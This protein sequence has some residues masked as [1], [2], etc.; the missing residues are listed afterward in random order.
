[1]GSTLGTDAPRA[2][3]PTDIR[4]LAPAVG[5]WLCT[6]VLLGSQSTTALT[7]GA[8][9]L[10][11]ALVL[12]PALRL[13]SSDLWVTPVL[14][15]L[16]CAAAGALA[17]GA[18][19]AGVEASPVAELAERESGV[20]SEVVVSLDPRPRDGDALPGRV[21]HVIEAHTVWV[22]SDGE[23]SRSRVPVV[24][25]TSGPEWGGLVPG[26][27]VELS[28]R[29]VPAEEPGLVRG[30]VLVRGPPED[31]EPPGTPR[32]LAEVARERLRDAA[33]SLPEPANAL[34]P[35][36]VVGDVSELA[37]ATAEDFR[38]TGMT[39]L[40]TVSG[41]NLAVLTGV[42]LGFGR[43]FGWP[44]WLTASAGAVTIAVFILVARAE[45]SVLRAAVMGGIALLAL[46]LGRRRAGFTAL[47]A[48]VVG[49]LLFD[50]SL[51]R[52]YGFAL[53]VLATA[54]ILVLAP[55]WRDAWSARLPR[56]LAEAVAVALAAHVG[57]V[58]V[59]V[60]LS[61][62]VSWIAVP[63]NVLASPVT[64]VATMGGFVVMGLALVWPAAAA[65]VVWLPGVAVIG[66]GAVATHA[67][68]VPHGAFS[69]RD[70]FLGV[71]AAAVLVL[72]FLTARG[73]VRR[74]LCALGVVVV[75]VPVLLHWL[76]PPWP[77]AG[78]TV[79]ACDV[80][81]GDAFVLSLGDG[82]A[83]LVDTGARPTLVD[84]CLRDLGVRSLALLVLTHGDVDHDGAVAGVLAGRASGA[85]LV[86]GGYDSPEAERE[87]AE[88]SVPLRTAEAGQRWEVG[89]WHL[90]VLWPRGGARDSNDNSVVL[91]ARWVPP[92]DSSARPMTALL[93]G[94][95]EEPAQRALRGEHA[96]R[97]VDLLKTPH[98]GAKTQDADFLTATRPRVTITSVGEDNPHGH[99]DPG[100]WSLLT[101]LTRASYRTDLHGD[102]A[103]VPGPDGP[104]VAVRATSQE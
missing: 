49:L 88:S 85:A 46:A 14:A 55:G 39:H 34:L 101:S 48:S 5:T 76:A 23:R 4:L 16:V 18:R 90:D 95:I 22:A 60:L 81:Q 37:D 2:A 29:L 35:A 67:A 28:G 20:T 89:P 24:L 83:L 31:V 72:V 96:I 7:T 93:T 1:M 54:G 26:T 59:L 42:A 79:V 52:S 19:L 97:G 33:A 12:S 77:P 56:W 30:L 62:E 32:M 66:V 65:V 51:A 71:V 9:L 8:A 68:R 45:P 84:G 74:V 13:P 78:W 87:L 100:T 63:A 82:R 44:P 98:H 43:W 99:P 86:P 3:A 27:T 91:L 17:V 53:S 102:I 15:V 38:D 73:R 57:C 41:A 104:E 11:C 50:P 40:L 36:M 64:P 80:G 69:W 92:P 10:G 70:D 21:E 47:A 58:P 94:D 6:A 61:A 25:L 75:V 103:V